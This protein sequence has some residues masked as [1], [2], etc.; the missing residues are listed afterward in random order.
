MERKFIAKR[1]SFQGVSG[2]Q[3]EQ[4]DEIGYCFCSQFIEE[5]SFESYLKEANINKEDVSFE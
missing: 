3:F 1:C 2:Y 4:Y 5:N